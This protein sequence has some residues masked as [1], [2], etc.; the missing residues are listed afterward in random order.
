MSTHTDSTIQKRVR[1]WHWVD[2]HLSQLFPKD[3][4][5]NLNSLKLILQSDG[6]GFVP[7]ASIIWNMRGLSYARWIAVYKIVNC[8]LL[9][10]CFHKL[11]AQR[12]C[13]HWLLIDIHI[14]IGDSS[15]K[16][17]ATPTSCEPELQ[18]YLIMSQ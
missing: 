12:V 1:G 16:C 13:A 2:L 11:R 6:I 9:F 10:Y 5:G 8:I 17:H 14:K 7:A 3:W 15:F 18:I 4:V